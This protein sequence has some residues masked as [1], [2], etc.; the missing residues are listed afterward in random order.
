MAS[1]KRKSL[2]TCLV[3]T[4]AVFAAFLPSLRNGFVGYDDPEY[5]TENPHVRGGLTAENVMWAFTSAHSNNWHPLT[6]VS[7]ALDTMLFGLTPAGHHLMSL[8]LHIASTVLLFLWL[9]GAT[10]RLGPSAFVALGFGLHP[11]HVESVA[12]VAERKD[13]LSTFFLISML[14]AYTAYVR[15]PSLIRYAAVA[16][17]FAAGLMS[18]PMLVTAPLLLCLL[19]RWPLKLAGWRIVEKL[20]LAAL[21]ALS[22][23]VTV[24]AQRQGGAIAAVDQLPLDVRLA[25][26]MVSYFRY[27][28]KTVWPA[29]LS[30]FY[31]FAAVPVWKAVAAGAVL[32]AITALVFARRG[33]S[34]WLA[35]GWGWFLIALV[36]VIG[37]VQVGMQSMADR[38]MYVPMIGLLIAVSWEVRPSRLSAAVAVLLLGAWAALSWQQSLVWHDGVTLWT[39]ALAVDPNNFVAHDN[40]GVELDRLGRFDDALAH[41]NETIRIRPGDRNGE[42][43]FAR[44]SYAKGQRLVAARRL[45]EA[46]AQYRLAV[47][48]DPTLAPAYMGLGVALSWADRPDEAR[49]A[50]ESALR[51]DPNNVEAH[52]DLGLVLAVKGRSAD[53]IREFDTAI[54]LN[55]NFAPAR[56]ARAEL[57]SNHP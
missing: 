32:A 12:W 27:L 3:L 4:L 1:A 45:D 19:D 34:P 33:Q 36:P 28:A 46:I 18:K 24:W 17:V 37:I 55:P 38:Y 6:W 48:H 39:H 52:F 26:A 8:L 25:N 2:L 11:L 13:V 20:P 42:S 56:E 15:R 23:A 21:S 35:T 41:Y 29:G 10:G 40:L 49:R 44:A 30:A 5:V 47:K 57:L 53:A 54:R 14:M 22:C 43:N 31:P 50:F 16:V 7:H 51:Y 9:N